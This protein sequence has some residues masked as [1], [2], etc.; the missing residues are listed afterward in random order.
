VTGDL[1]EISGVASKLVKIKDERN[2]VLLLSMS[3]VGSI[4]RVELLLASKMKKLLNGGPRNRNSDKVVGGLIGR[5]ADTEGN[6][7]K[8]RATN[9]KGLR[10]LNSELENFLD[11][12]I[13]EL[14]KNHFVC[15]I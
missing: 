2:V 12:A 13:V 8:V 1:L 6:T 4:E 9:L 15:K 3:Q 10:L 14:Q 11:N 7:I 5:S